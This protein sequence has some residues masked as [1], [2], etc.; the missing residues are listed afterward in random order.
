MDGGKT[1]QAPA[2]DHAEA[3]PTF[4]EIA[5]TFEL[6]DDWEERY[7]YVIELGKDLPGLPEA[8]RTPERKVDGCV[9]QVWLDVTVAPD[10]AGTRR[11]SFHGDSDALIVRGL[12]AILISLL[13]GRPAAEVA[14]ENVHAA[15]GRIGLDNAL[16]AQRSNGLR[17]MVARLQGIAAHG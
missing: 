17:A 7:R 5:E 1:G 12:I 10:A 9:S 14:K 13:S 2:A 3:T 15:L 6:L 16:S 4:E 11:I 8:E